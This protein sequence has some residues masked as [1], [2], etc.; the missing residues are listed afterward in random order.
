MW[1]LSDW[2]LNKIL[3]LLRWKHAVFFQLVNDELLLSECVD[4]F[5]SFYVC[6]INNVAK[7]VLGSECCQVLITKRC[8]ENIVFQSQ[9]AILW[10]VYQY[11]SLQ[12]EHNK[13]LIRSSK[14]LIVQRSE[15]QAVFTLLY[16]QILFELVNVS[17]FNQVNW[18]KQCTTHNNLNEHL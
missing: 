6:N 4:I 7:L 13:L 3:F 12:N 18:L 10:T 15:V 2:Y 5:A 16:I 1:E 11:L 9:C 17:L 8:V 14:R